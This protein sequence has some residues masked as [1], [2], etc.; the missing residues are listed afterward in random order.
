MKI[1]IVI[2]IISV[3]PMAVADVNSYY[4]YAVTED[5]D[6]EV[7]NLYA[8][9]A[10][11]DEETLYFFLGPKSDALPITCDDSAS[12]CT[13][14]YK[15]QIFYVGTDDDNFVIAV[16]GGYGDDDYVSIET[17]SDTQEMYGGVYINGWNF[18]AK[19]NAEDPLSF[20]EDKFS[21]LAEPFVADSSTYGF[22]LQLE[23]APRNITTD[24]GI[25]NPSNIE[26]DVLTTESESGIHS[27]TETDFSTAS[28]GT[29]SSII[30]VNATL[31]TSESRNSSA[32]AGS[33]SPSISS[34]EEE[35]ASSSTEAVSS[36]DSSSITFDQATSGEESSTGSPSS[37]S[38]TS[39]GDAQS[40]YFSS[41]IGLI[42]VLFAL[43]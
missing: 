22:R 35:N 29:F 15:D 20:S 10:L 4:F 18:Y 40:K 28:S 25:F 12:I 37:R 11:E 7:D 41:C 14:T 3:V 32:T 26:V 17:N 33:D 30:S 34:A 19:E 21:I 23:I 36:T 24:G 13:V 16:N 39:S 38:Q 43:F 5:G 2:S 8:Q 9:A 42:A 1:S 6:T 27:E 31:T